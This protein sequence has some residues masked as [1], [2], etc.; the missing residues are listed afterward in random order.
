MEW[1][2]L[3]GDVITRPSRNEGPVNQMMRSRG[4]MYL[5]PRRSHNVGHFAR[6]NRRFCQGTRTFL[7]HIARSPVNI[8]TFLSHIAIYHRQLHIY[9]TPSVHKRCW[10]NRLRLQSQPLRH[11]LA[12]SSSRSHRQRTHTKIVKKN[13]SNDPQLGVS[14]VSFGKSYPPLHLK[15][16]FQPRIG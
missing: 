6:R 11:R 9:I 4:R 15:Y 1:S 12:P 7:L 14:S 16:P 3:E 8:Q 5:F 2:E 13:P 10:P